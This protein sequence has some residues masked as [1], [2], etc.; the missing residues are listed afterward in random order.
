M[1]EKIYKVSFI[2]ML[3]VWFV[4]GVNA[5]DSISTNHVK[6]RNNYITVNDHWLIEIPIWLPGFNGNLSYGDIY[7]ESVD[8]SGSGNP[9]DPGGH[10]SDILSRVFGMDS[11][12]N[13]FFLNKIAYRNKKFYSQFD[14][15]SGSIGKSVFFQYN[16]ADLVQMK[17]SIFLFRLFAGYKFYETKSNSEKWNYTLHGYGGVRIYKTYITSEFNKIDKSLEV[18]PLWVEPIIG[19]RN[20]FTLKKWRFL[21]QADVGNFNIGGKLSYMINFDAYFRINNL[22]SIKAGWNDLDVRF[23]DNYEGEELK[24]KMHFS[25]PAL[26]L[27]FHF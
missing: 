3:L 1:V 10:T 11:N 9:N 16:N 5:Q 26:A 23:Q 22:L 20:E 15:I 21:L 7:L 25:G 8:F 12:L 19:V 14:V 17:F 18:E 4:W 6:H 13:Y 2:A 24:L 27:T